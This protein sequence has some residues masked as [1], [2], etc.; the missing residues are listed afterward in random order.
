M[1]ND[2]SCIFKSLTI[3]TIVFTRRVILSMPI[4]WDPIDRGYIQL[5]LDSKVNNNNNMLF[6]YISRVHN[7]A[8]YD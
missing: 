5:Y 4:P 3:Y 2:I 8:I 7:Q 6:S 1:P